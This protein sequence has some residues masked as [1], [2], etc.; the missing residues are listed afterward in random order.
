MAEPSPYM[1]MAFKVKPAWRE[2][3]Q[4]TTH[5]NDTAR[6]QTV[7]TDTAPNYFQVIK[8]FG[9]LT[10]VPVVL[11]TSFNI[12]GQPIVETPLEALST[13]SATGMDSLFMGPFMVQKPKKP[14]AGKFRGTSFAGSAPKVK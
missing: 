9:D 3:L 11:N 1:T 7:S 8:S 14:R 12:K 2:T 13:F 5:V 4:A 6:V 10:G